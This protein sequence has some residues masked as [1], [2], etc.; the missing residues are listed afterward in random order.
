MDI[1]KL[2]ELRESGNLVSPGTQYTGGPITI[3]DTPAFGGMDFFK[4]NET[5]FICTQVWLPQVTWLQLER[6]G[7]NSGIYVKIGDRHYICRIPYVGELKGDPNEW[8][9]LLSKLNKRELELVNHQKFSFWGKET[10]K[11]G[12]QINWNNRIIRGGNTA[13]ARSQRPINFADHKLGF[14]PVLQRLPLEPDLFSIQGHNVCV[15]GPCGTSIAGQL[16]SVSNYDVILQP[17]TAVPGAWSGWSRKD[18]NEVIIE[19]EKIKY[20]VE[21]K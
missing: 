6:S 7:F 17:I 10:A 20:V 8:D 3:E 16:I 21:E 2:G 19:K 5:F 11:N 4:L 15:F 18:G 1:V 14:R 12:S 9:D 13:V